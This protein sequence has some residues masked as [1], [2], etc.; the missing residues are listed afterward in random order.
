MGT[1]YSKWI[2]ISRVESA[3]ETSVSLTFEFLH[4]DCLSNGGVL[5]LCLSHASL[6]LFGVCSL[7]QLEPL[8][9]VLV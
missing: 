6:Y 3:D 2:G 5:C 4:A 8:Y 9:S 7:V 1:A